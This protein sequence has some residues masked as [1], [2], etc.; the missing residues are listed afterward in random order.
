MAQQRVAQI[1]GHLYP[2]GMLAGQVA[3]ITGSGQGIGAE[4]A[5]LFAKEGAKVVVQDID[6]DLIGPFRAA[7]AQSVVDKIT[8]AGGTAIAVSGDMLDANYID[9]LVKKAAEFGGG[10]IH[11]IVNNAGFTWDGVIHKVSCLQKRYAIPGGSLY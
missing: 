1:A 6:G 3:I 7:K 11:I 10:R 9:E 4:A 2:H 5:Q 8:Q